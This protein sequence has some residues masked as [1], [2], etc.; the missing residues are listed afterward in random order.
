M[1]RFFPDGRPRS[2]LGRLPSYKDKEEI[3]K[4]AK[5]LR[6]TKFF[7]NPDFS[8]KVRLNRNCCHDSLKNEREATSHT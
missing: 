7:I 8:E 1:A 3:L 5:C 6:V 4:R 2:I